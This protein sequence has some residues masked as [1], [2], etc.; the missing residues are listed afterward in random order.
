MIMPREIIQVLTPLLSHCHAAYQESTSV[1]LPM[2]PYFPRKGV[3]TNAFA[4]KGQRPNRPLVQMAVPNT[5][6]E[7]KVSTNYRDRKG[8]KRLSH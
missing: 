7:P 3:K 8:P 6:I 5:Q 2:G 1:A 4:L